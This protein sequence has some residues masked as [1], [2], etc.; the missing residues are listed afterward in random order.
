SLDEVDVY[1]G[2]LVHGH[3]IDPYRR[4]VWIWP[5]NTARSNGANAIA[6]ENRMISC[7]PLRT[8]GMTGGVSVQGDYLFRQC[9]GHLST[10]EQRVGHYSSL[11]EKWSKPVFSR[12]KKP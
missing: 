10:I 4:G 11:E 8:N 1:F 5:L 12:E 7:Q 9:P 6:N 3:R 2:W